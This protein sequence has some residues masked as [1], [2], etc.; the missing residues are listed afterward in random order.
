MRCGY[1]WGL[2]LHTASCMAPSALMNWPR[3]LSGSALTPWNSEKTDVH[4]LVSAS[5][6]ELAWQRVQ[7]LASLQAAQLD[8]VSEQGAHVGAST[9]VP[10]HA[11]M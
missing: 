7:V 4:F 5:S 2:E 6:T 10:T 11:F 8:S 3:S 1:E 9:S